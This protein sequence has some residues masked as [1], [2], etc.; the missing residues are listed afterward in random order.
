[1][2][3]QRQISAGSRFLADVFLRFGVSGLGSEVR[4]VEMGALLSSNLMRSIVASARATLLGAMMCG[5]ENWA[6]DSRVWDQG[7]KK[8]DRW[9]I[10]GHL[11][12]SEERCSSVN[13]C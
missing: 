6:R 1:M 10:D 9:G 12:R 7:R 3:C 11:L 13:Q 5:A 8:G 4:G 2:I